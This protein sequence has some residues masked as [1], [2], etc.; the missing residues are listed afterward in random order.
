MDYD[1]AKRR[2][3]AWANR[4]YDSEITVWRGTKYETT[5]FEFAGEVA[6]H[7]PKASKGMRGWGYV[8]CPTW[9]SPADYHSLGSLM[10]ICLDGHASNHPFDVGH[11]LS[12]SVR[13]DA[14]TNNYSGNL[15]LMYPKGD[16]HWGMETSPLSF[17]R[18]NNAFLHLRSYCLTNNWQPMLDFFAEDGPEEYRSDVSKWLD[19]LTRASQSQTA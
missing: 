14:Q 1:N 3:A 5:C 16:T 4:S 9:T 17:K 6:A 18:D 10:T 2:L 12:A 19:S 15:T 13:Y 11:Y 8:M 7:I